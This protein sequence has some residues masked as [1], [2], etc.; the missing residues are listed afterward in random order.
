MS[1]IDDIIII[2]RTHKEKGNDKEIFDNKGRDQL[3]ISR[4]WLIS[5]MLFDNL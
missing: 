2:N 1:D 4:K 3:S 5:W